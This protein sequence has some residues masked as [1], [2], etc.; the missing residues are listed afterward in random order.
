MPGLKRDVKERLLKTIEEQK[1]AQTRQAQV[2][3]PM[4]QAAA[5]A[6]VKAKEAK[7]AQTL[8]HLS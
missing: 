1:A 5:H 6:D 3:M 8:A 2:A 4:Q 7:T